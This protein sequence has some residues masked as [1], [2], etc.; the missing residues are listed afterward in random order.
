VVRNVLKL[1]NL[2]IIA[3]T[4]NAMESDREDCIAAGMNGHIGKP[5]DLDHL[6]QTLLSLA[7]FTPKVIKASGI[8]H[9]VSKVDSPKQMPV[10]G[11]LDVGAALRRLGGNTS[12]YARAAK[13][14]L[15]TLQQQLDEIASQATQGGPSTP[16]LAH[17]LKGVAATLGAQSL[18]QAA[19]DVE[20]LAKA[21]ESVLRLEPALA[22]LRHMAEQTRSELDAAIQALASSDA[23]TVQGSNAVIGSNPEEARAALHKLHELLENNDLGALEHYSNS[24]ALF[25]DAPEELLSALEFALQELNLEAALEACDQLQSAS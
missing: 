8:A 23:T 20:Q 15:H 25:A 7:D 13:D 9:L 3:M 24:Q 22:H 21:G 1:P 17:T 5:F 16:L 10:S 12:V 6:V 18:A 2:P 14:F 11:S 4:A 19:A